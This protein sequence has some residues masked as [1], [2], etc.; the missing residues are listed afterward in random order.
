MGLRKL[1]TWGS[2]SIVGHI[3]FI[4]PIGFLGFLALG[5]YGNYSDGT[6]TWDWIPYIVMY[7][8]LGGMLC[9]I[10]AWCGTYC[11]IRQRRKGP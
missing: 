9:A 10:I 6:L 8:L 4:G 2:K 1:L 3:V 5:V 7:S 11:L